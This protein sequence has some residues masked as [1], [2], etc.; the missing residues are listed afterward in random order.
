[1]QLFLI[2]IAPFHWLDTVWDELIYDL[3]RSIISQ[4]YEEGVIQ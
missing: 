3:T 2:F 4:T 1:M